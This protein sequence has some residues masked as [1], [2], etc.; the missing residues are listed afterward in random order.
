MTTLREKLLI[1]GALA[2]L[3]A[4]FAWLNGGVRVDVNL[5]LVRFSGVPLPV[6]VFTAFL[7]GMLTLFLA[8]LK[9]ELRTQRMLRRYRD[10]LSTEGAPD[11]APPRPTSSDRPDD[12]G[13]A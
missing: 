1:G 2:L 4:A 3:S 6:L 10:L 12:R 11:A 13:P 7:L 8:G 5:G 9:A